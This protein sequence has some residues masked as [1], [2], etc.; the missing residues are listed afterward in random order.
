MFPVYTYHHCQKPGCGLALVLDGNMKNNR[1]VCCATFAWYAEVEGQK[2]KIRT[3][4]PN[5][6]TF[7]SSFCGVHAPTVAVCQS[8]LGDEIVPEDAQMSASSSEKQ[9]VG[10]II[11]KRVIRNSTLYK[12]YIHV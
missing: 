12:V 1:Y 6:P 7:K 8:L 10:L 5:T 2:G 9:P 11:D 3:G 4:C